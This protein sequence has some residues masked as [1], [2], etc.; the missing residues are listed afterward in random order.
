VP[1]AQGGGS[2]SAR[3]VAVQAKPVSAAGELVRFASESDGPFDRCLSGSSDVVRSRSRPGVVA[4]PSSRSWAPSTSSAPPPPVASPR[5]SGPGAPTSPTSLLHRRHPL[6][7]GPF[8]GEPSPADEAEAR[9]A[10]TA[11]RERRL[12]AAARGRPGQAPHGTP[13]SSDGECLSQR[14]VVSFRPARCGDP[15]PVCQ[16]LAEDGASCVDAMAGTDPNDE[17][18]ADPEFLRLGRL[19]WRGLV[20]RGAGGGLAAR[21]AARRAGSPGGCAT[22]AGAC[23]ESTESC[24]ANACG[25]A[26]CLT[27]CRTAADCAAGYH[28]GSRGG[29]S[30]TCSTGSHHAPGRRA[31]DRC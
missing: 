24:G 26:A 27:G 4:S 2:G 15:C 13:C 11:E 30:P 29:A 28:C 19:Q 22:R 17:C 8:A 1:G 20:P 23:V 7:L 10:A 31:G 12:G 6:V 25:G 16:V 21:S 5:P 14:C 9:E 18:T 3:R